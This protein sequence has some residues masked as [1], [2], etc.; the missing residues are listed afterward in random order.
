MFLRPAFYDFS[1]FY[2]FKVCYM[3]SPGHPKGRFYQPVDFVYFVFNFDHL[4]LVSHLKLDLVCCIWDHH[5]WFQSCEGSKFDPMLNSLNLYLFNKF[6]YQISYLYFHHSELGHLS[7][8]RLY[9]E[10]CNRLRDT[11]TILLSYLR[12]FFEFITNT[13]LLKIF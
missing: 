13:N 10:A 4:L 1:N 7:T 6:V 2:D 9:I 8:I 11:N 12:N 3:T 5:Y